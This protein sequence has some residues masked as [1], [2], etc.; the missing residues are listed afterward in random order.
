MNVCSGSEM[1][2]KT[3]ISN[4]TSCDSI[5]NQNSKSKSTLDTAGE[6]TSVQYN[7]S[8]KSA[9]LY[10]INEGSFGSNSE[11]A[12]YTLLTPL[13]IKKYRRLFTKLVQHDLTYNIVIT[14]TIAAGK[15]TKCDLFR[16]LMIRVDRDLKHS[17]LYP[18]YLMYSDIGNIM[19]QKLHD[20]TISNITFQHYIMDEFNNILSKRPPRNINLFERCPDDATFIFCRGMED[21]QLQPIFKRSAMIANKYNIPRFIESIPQ[22]FFTRMENYGSHVFDK[23]LDIM[24]RDVNKMVNHN[25]KN[26]H[27]IFGLVVSPEESYTRMRVRNRAAESDCDIEFMKICYNN[28]NDLYDYLDEHRDKNDYDDA[29]HGDDGDGE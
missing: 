13:H 18:E 4:N 9:Q 1:H 20:G 17:R 28:Y 12:S 29:D 2:E 15:S 11:L 25:L 21:E 10:E 23:M 16:E 22:Y 8:N 19:L 6:N 3:P 14:G 24:E 26:M 7:K 27:R 5:E